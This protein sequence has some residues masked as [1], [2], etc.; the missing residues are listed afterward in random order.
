MS[1]RTNGKSPQR[2]ESAEGIEI[3]APRMCRSTNRQAEPEVWFRII[4]LS[5]DGRNSTPVREGI[6]RTRVTQI[7]R[8]LRLAPEIQDQLVP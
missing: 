2:A 5:L 4:H 1:I 3:M 6:T 7:L 8:L